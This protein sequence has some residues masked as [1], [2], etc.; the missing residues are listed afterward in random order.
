MCAFSGGWAA[1]VCF[2]DHL[3]VDATSAEEHNAK[4]AAAIDGSHVR[5]SSAT[6]PPSVCAAPPPAPGSSRSAGAGTASAA[7]AA[8]GSGG[9]GGGAAR[10]V[11]APS[12]ST[13]ITDVDTFELGFDTGGALP[14]RF[15]AAVVY[16]CTHRECVLLLV[17]RHGCESRRK[18]AAD[19]VRA[20]PEEC[21]ASH[22]QH[23]CA[24]TGG[25]QSLCT[26]NSLILHAMHPPQFFLQNSTLKLFTNPTAASVCPRPWQ[27]RCLLAAA[28]AAL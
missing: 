19:A 3:R 8:A 11:P 27:R 18:T 23:H 21:P 5:G 1:A 10:G 20:I 26:H 4:S 15:G 25:R 2:V 13:A 17:R 22:Q 6:A 24:G 7:P 9:G 14:L 16:G 12:V 28:P